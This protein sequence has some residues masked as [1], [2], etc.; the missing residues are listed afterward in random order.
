MRRDRAANVRRVFVENNR[1]ALA[2]WH[3]PRTV[4]PSERDAMHVRVDRRCISFKKFEPQPPGFRRPWAAF[5]A[6][7]SER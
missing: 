4:D 3:R 5:E 7:K 6:P 2:A 1:D